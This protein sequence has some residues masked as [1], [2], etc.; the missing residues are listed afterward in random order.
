MASLW[1]R[2][3]TLVSL[4]PSCSNFSSSKTS[5]G[6]LQ[7]LAQNTTNVP[8]HLPQQFF[9]SFLI[10]FP[11]CSCVIHSWY[12]LLPSSLSGTM[13]K[14]I[15][16]RTQKWS[17]HQG[18]VSNSNSPFVFGKKN[19]IYISLPHDS[20]VIC[21]PE[22]CCYFTL[23]ADVWFSLELQCIDSD[24]GK[25]AADS[26]L[27]VSWALFYIVMTLDNNNLGAVLDWTRYICPC[28]VVETHPSG[29]PSA[30]IVSSF[31]TSHLWHHFV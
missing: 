4:Y 9:H 30:V 17:L 6:F 31:I 18:K 23:A 24:Y 29:R 19:T 15:R 16:K 25:K 14:T 21:T 20:P 11:S 7:K 28:S 2:G 27:V 10:L 13:L 3:S 1:G 12:C 8:R 22:L 26:V 5:P